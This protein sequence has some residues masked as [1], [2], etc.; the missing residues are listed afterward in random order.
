MS[1]REDLITEEEQKEAMIL[2][3]S[4]MQGRHTPMYFALALMKS[5]RTERI[6]TAA[7]ALIINAELHNVIAVQKVGG[8]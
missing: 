1:D 2:L 6:K 8:N 5:N 3:E 7:V 4:I